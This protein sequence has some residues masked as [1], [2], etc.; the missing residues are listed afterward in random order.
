MY[1]YAPTLSQVKCSGEPFSRYQDYEENL[2][3]VGLKTLEEQ[4]HQ[5]DMA[6]VYR[7]LTS[8]DNVST[9]TWFSMMGDS[10]R[11]TRSIAGPLNV[12]VTHGRLEIR[13]HFFSVRVISLWNAVPS[14]IKKKLRTVSS[15][16]N[17]YAKYRQS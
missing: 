9:D 3:E 13:R 11:E 7:I 6:M 1:L 15:F 4:R 14:E 8:K 5:A 16:K 10:T 2:K 17:A 12:K